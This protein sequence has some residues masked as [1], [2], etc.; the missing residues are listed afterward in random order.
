MGVVT[1]PDSNLEQEL[2]RLMELYEKDILRMCYVYLKDLSQAQDAVQETFLKAYKALQGFRGESSEKTW[3]MRIAIN[4]C[5]DYRRNAWFRFVD[6][7]VEI[8]TLNLSSAMPDDETAALFQEV[9]RL[10]PKLK[11]AVLLYYYQGLKL[12]EAA[13]ALGLTP[14][15]VSK[16][17]KQACKKLKIELEGGS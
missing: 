4:T 10:P 3:L 1:G 8:D 5:K 16:R 13:Q 12:E 17:L 6:R 11:E 15:A 14:A 7:R 9:L 2:I